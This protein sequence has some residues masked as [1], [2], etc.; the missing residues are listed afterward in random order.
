M[1]PLRLSHKR[2][3]AHRHNFYLL[4]TDTDIIVIDPCSYFVIGAIEI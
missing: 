2:V 1:P 4:S 3:L